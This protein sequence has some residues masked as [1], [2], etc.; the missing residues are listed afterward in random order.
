MDKANENGK[1][2]KE[3]G[4]PFEDIPT[5]I[6]TQNHPYKTH[7]PNTEPCNCRH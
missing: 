6:Q 2:K 4:N 1:G 5:Q 3:V 7:S